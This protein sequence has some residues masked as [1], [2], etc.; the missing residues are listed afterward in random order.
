MVLGGLSLETQSIMKN[1][2]KNHSEKKNEK[3]DNKPTT[4]QALRIARLYRRRETTPWSAKEIRAF[5][6]IGQISMEE[7]ET[8]CRYE[9]AEM[10]KGDD[11][12]HRRDLLTFLNNFH[13]ERDRA[14]PKASPEKKQPQFID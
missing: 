7:L 5:K 3:K 10:A 11:G 12:R 4:T 9:E 8:V 6:A 13:G 1:L 2:M 14:Q